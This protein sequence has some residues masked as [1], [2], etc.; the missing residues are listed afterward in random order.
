MVMD[1]KEHQR[2]YRSKNRDLINER[3]RARNTRPDVREYN[4]RRRVER[5]EKH[6]TILIERL[7]GCCEH[8]GATDNL[9]FNHRHPGDKSFS[10]TLKLNGPLDVVMMESDKC[11]LLCSDCHR[12]LTS[13][14]KRVAWQLLCDLSP[15]DYDKLI[16]HTP[17]DS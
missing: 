6:R 16:N 2:R 9:E 17:T 5:V 11:Q 4:R 14:Q 15:S 1:N 8:C 7:G 13:Q 10:V 3:N 12:K